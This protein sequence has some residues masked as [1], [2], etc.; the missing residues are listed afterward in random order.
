M[1]QLDNN[2]GITTLI[3]LII[4]RGGSFKSPVRASGDS[5]YNLRSLSEKRQWFNHLRMLEQKQHLL[6]NYF[7]TLSE[8]S[9][10][11]PYFPVRQTGTSP[12]I[13]LTRPISHPFSKVLRQDLFSSYFIFF[14][15]QII[16]NKA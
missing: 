15:Y 14:S 8:G 6:L 12:L 7:M 13:K 11:T 2:N 10:G 4:A 1:K 16:S 5:I 9:A 3:F